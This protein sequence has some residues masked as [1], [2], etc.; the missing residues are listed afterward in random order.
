MRP[1]YAAIGWRVNAKDVM[2]IGER[3]V[4]LERLYDFRE[5]ITRKD[6]TLPV[7]YLEESLP[8][9]HPKGRL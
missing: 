7:R 4:N 3:I 6:D 9:A 2:E 8:K 1:I 5:G